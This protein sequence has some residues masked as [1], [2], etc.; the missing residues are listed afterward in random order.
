MSDDDDECG[1]C[2]CC[3][4]FGVGAMVIVATG[5]MDD[6]LLTVV[7]II[8]GIILLTCLGICMYD[9]CYECGCEC[10]RPT[11]MFPTI[12]ITLTIRRPAPVT[13]PAI[14]NSFR[15]KEKEV[16]CT[17]CMEEIKINSKCKKIPGCG[18]QFHKKCIDTW[19]N[20]S[21]TCPNCRLDV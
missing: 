13:R 10:V 9:C 7:G 8:S 1:G 4:M 12:N 11:I 16:I 21:K 5:G 17:V 3:L 19:L 14:V 6:V 20:E 2:I 15:I 18:H